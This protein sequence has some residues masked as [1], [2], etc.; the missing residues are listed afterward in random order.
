[1]NWLVVSSY[2]GCPLRSLHQV[3][4]FQPKGWTSFMPKFIR[5][6]C[7][8]GSRCVPNSV[9]RRWNSIK[10]LAVYV[11]SM[12]DSFTWGSSLTETCS[13]SCFTLKLSCPEC[14]KHMITLSTIIEISL[15]PLQKIRLACAYVK[16]VSDSHPFIFRGSS[17]LAEKRV[18]LFI[19]G[20]QTQKYGH[21]L[22]EIELHAI[23]ALWQDFME[24]FNTC[25]E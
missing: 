25:R 3:W 17:Q 24:W 19:I 8:V 22:V 11:K 21:P 15:L 14:R 2:L 13:S 1:M 4:G 23:M 9:L 10:F 6:W 7:R 12:C 20:W 18:V 16:V 5:V